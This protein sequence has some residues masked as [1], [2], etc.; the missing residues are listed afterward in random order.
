MTLTL[1]WIFAPLSINSCTIFR[2]P[3]C[4][5]HINE[6][7]PLLCFLRKDKKEEE[8]EGREGEGEDV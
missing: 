8:E 6:V 4:A 7:L 2:W 3:S 5:A 1:S